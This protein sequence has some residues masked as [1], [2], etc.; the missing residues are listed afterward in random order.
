AGISLLIT[1]AV[2]AL[3]IVPENAPMR[4]EGGEIIRSPFMDSLVPIIAIIFFVPGLVYGKV[5]KQIQNDKDVDNKLADTMASTGM[6]SVH[7]FLAREFVVFFSESQ[8]GLIF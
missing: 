1:V 7:S 3:L 6:F 4:G 2:M 5:T 8:F